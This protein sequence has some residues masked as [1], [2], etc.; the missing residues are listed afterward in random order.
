MK[1]MCNTH[2]MKP[3][4]SLQLR[5]LEKVNYFHRDCQSATYLACSVRLNIA[6]TGGRSRSSAMLARMANAALESAHIIRRILPAIPIRHAVRGARL[7]VALVCRTLAIRLIR[8]TVRLIGLHETF[9]ETLDL[10]DQLLQLQLG[11]S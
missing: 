5:S 7:T 8:L 10:L 2:C 3:N 11:V 9:V 6:R 4:K 1:A